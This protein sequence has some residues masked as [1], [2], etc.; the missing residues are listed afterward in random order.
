MM[1]E[2]FFPDFAEDFSMT[3]LTTAHRL[4]TLLD[5]TCLNDG[6]TETDIKKVKKGD[7]LD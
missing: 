5:L 6:D 4:V 7:R 3:D 1:W 2:C